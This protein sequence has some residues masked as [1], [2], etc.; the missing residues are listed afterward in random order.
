MGY[1]GAVDGGCTNTG[2]TSVGA[3][4]RPLE[5]DEILHVDIEIIDIGWDVKN[6]R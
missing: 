2:T 6:R 5:E 1:L 4:G 3:A